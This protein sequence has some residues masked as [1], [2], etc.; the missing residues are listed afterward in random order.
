MSRRCLALASLVPPFDYSV[1]SR[2]RDSNVFVAVNVST[3]AIEFVWLWA[4]AR[5]FL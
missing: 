3:E 2:W 4:M 5:P 1:P